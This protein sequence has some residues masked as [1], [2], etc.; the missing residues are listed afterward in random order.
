MVIQR[1]QN[2]IIGRYLASFV[3][4]VIAALGGFLTGLGLISEAA[5]AQ[6]VDSTTAIIVGLILWA[7]AQ[8][9]SLRDKKDHP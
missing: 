5:L 4:T 7:I 6:W 1:I 3:R 8:G 9:W 2:A